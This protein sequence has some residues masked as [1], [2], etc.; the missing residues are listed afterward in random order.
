MGY[1]SKQAGKR[2]LVKPSPTTPDFEIHEFHVSSISCHSP[3][4]APSMCFSRLA[5]G[6]LTAVKPSARDVFATKV[7]RPALLPKVFA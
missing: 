5:F 2:A 3:F 1:A 6:K 7:R 4:E